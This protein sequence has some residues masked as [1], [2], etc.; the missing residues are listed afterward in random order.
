MTSS[1]R[2]SAA[3][4]NTAACRIGADVVSVTSVG[5]FGCLLGWPV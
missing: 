2:R 1:T 4:A 5:A 3:S